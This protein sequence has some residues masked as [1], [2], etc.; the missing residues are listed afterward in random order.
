MTHLKTVGEVRVMIAKEEALQTG[1]EPP[2]LVK[3]ALH[4]VT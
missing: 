1:D 3:R 2:G 4:V